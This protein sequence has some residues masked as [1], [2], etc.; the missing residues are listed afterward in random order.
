MRIIKCVLPLLL[1]AGILLA[2][3]NFNGSWKLN[4]QKC[5]F[6]S[7]QVP[8]EETIVIADDGDQVRVII[9]G[10]D[11]AGAPIAITY[12]VPAGGGTS[13]LQN[14][15]YNSV[16]MHPVGDDTRDFAYSRDGRR[17]IAHRMVVAGDGKTMTVSIKGVDSAGRAIDGVL[18]FDKK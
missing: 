7:G 14:G 11:Q 13:Q 9:T 4:H 10:V 2:V 3:T 18:V 5:R 8:K 1:S 12:S 15:S 16:L 6:T 17:I